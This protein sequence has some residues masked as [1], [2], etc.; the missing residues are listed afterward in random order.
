MLR[1]YYEQCGTLL[2]SL[3][4]EYKGR[5]TPGF[6]SFRP[7]EIAGRQTAWRKDDTRLHIDAFPSRPM[8]GLRILRIFTNIHRSEARHWRVGG[9]FEDVAE[10][11]WRQVRR[12]VPGSSW[13]LQ[14]LHITKGRRTPYDHLMLGIHDR[15]KADARYQNDFP[16]TDLRMKPRTTWVCFTDA[17][18]HAAM[19]GQF[20]LEQTFYLPVDAMR[21]PRQSPLRVLERL[22]GRVLA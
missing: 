15:M 22:T 10:R 2:R 1:R 5:L 4:P 21:E 8:Q 11:F 9:G 3:I 12:E 16:H 7:V 14:R 19:A 20:A 6:T 18:P 13:M 17:V